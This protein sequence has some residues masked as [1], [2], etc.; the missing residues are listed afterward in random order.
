MTQPFITP[1]RLLASRFQDRSEVPRW[2]AAVVCFRDVK[3]SRALVEALSAV[4]VGRKVLWGMEPT[5][6]LPNVYSAE[7]SGKQIALVTRCIW[8]GPQAAILVEELSAIGVPVVIGYGAAGSIDPSLPQGTQLVV[9]CAPATDGTSKH[10]GSGPFTPDPRLREL[11][12]SAVAVTAATADAIYR[13]TPETVEA[14][15]AQGAQVVNME[16]AP[17]YA[18]SEVRGLRAVWV[19]HV[20][21]HLIG[22]WKDWYLDRRGMDT[23]SIE[24]CLAVIGGVE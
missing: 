8:G 1:E 24:N 3:G 22:E 16:A 18:A 10:Y 12:P 19:G 23:G 5:S 15:R 21:D 14:W 2:D 17:F 9:S 4:P 20:S 13:E 6:E 11:V 7:V